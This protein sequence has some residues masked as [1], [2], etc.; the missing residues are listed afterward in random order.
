MEHLHS[1]PL[2]TTWISTLGKV[3]VAIR[4]NDFSFIE[5][6][7]ESDSFF[8]PVAVN[9]GNHE[10]KKSRVEVTVTGE[11]TEFDK[12]VEFYGPRGLDSDKNL[13]EEIE[14]NKGYGEAVDPIWKEYPESRHGKDR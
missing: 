4:G 13:Q 9:F 6:E 3:K 7:Y 10:L 11:M 5:T 8:N 14:K 1:T 2:R 12:Y